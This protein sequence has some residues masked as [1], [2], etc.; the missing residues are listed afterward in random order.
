MG[1]NY[2]AN[3]LVFL[4]QI[5]FGAYTLIVM[6]RFILQLVKAD[7]YNPVSQFVVKVTTPLLRPLRRIIPSMGGMDV[8]SIA[9]MWLVKSVELMFIL[10]LK[11]TGASSLLAAFV[12]SILELVEQAI[13]LFLFAILIQVIL[14]WVSPGGYNPVV[15]LIYSITDPLLRPARRI[16]PPIAGL[17]LSPM[18]VVIGLVLLKMLLLPPLQL[19]FATPFR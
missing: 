3:P 5:L 15:N 12:W 17:D 8:A 14:S 4:I 2:L 16:I 10:L 6:L 9:L 19:L 11:S 18:A 7:F 13:D 1:S